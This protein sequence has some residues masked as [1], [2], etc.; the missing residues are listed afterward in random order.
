MARSYQFFFCKEPDSRYFRPEGLSQL[1]PLQVKAARH[2]LSIDMEKQEQ[3]GEAEV[4]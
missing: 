1:Q 3:M 4:Q 2:L